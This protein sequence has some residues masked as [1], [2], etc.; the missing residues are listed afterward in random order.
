MNL[1][2]LP[3]LQKL[4][5]FPVLNGIVQPPLTPGQIGQIPFPIDVAAKKK[6]I[7]VSLYNKEK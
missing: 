4:Q 6:V 5:P 7:N 3:R 1:A 2:V